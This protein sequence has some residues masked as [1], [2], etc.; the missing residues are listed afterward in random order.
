MCELINM[1]ILHKV[2]QIYD[3]VFQDN[4]SVG[5]IAV[6]FKMKAKFDYIYNGYSK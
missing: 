1:N 3:K 2:S 6:L 4:D 5:F